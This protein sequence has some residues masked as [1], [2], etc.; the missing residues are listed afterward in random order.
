MLLRQLPGAAR[1][2]A[3]NN[4]AA[5]L[6]RRLRKRL[7]GIIYNLVESQYR[8]VPSHELDDGA[9]AVHGGAH[10]DTGKAELGNRR[11]DDPPGAKLIE[12]AF[13]DLISAIVLGH[14]FAHQE[15]RLIAAHF[16]YHRFAQSIAQCQFSCHCFFLT[17][18]GLLPR[19]EPIGL[20]NV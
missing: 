17:Y 13:A 9:Q 18:Q 11:I 7:G 3:E 16:F 6:A 10:A 15:D 4:R 12:H 5:E 20:F 2:P 1:R 8:K 14:L 19:L